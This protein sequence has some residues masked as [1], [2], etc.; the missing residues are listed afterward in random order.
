MCSVVSKQ[1]KCRIYSVHFSKLLFRFLP[2]TSRTTSSSTPESFLQSKLI[3]EHD[4]GY[5]SLDSVEALN[6]VQQDNPARPA[7]VDL[8]SGFCGYLCRGRSSC[9]RLDH[10]AERQ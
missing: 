10:W 3:S 1:V 4:S 6:E 2:S 7:D 9:G 5:S 8:G